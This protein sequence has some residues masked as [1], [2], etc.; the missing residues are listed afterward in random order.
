MRKSGVEQVT[1]IWYGVVI[2]SRTSLTEALQ[3][4]DTMS[5]FHFQT[6]PSLK[7]E[8]AKAPLPCH[9]KLW[10]APTAREWNRLKAQL[11]RKFSPP[12][13]ASNLPGEQALFFT[14]SALTLLRS[15]KFI[16]RT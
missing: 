3:L 5:S 4:L 8:D 2:T 12:P 16:T 13:K 10:D 1:A 6:R 15:A 11:P 9:E 7:L 14:P